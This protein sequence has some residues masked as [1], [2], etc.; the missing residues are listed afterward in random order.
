MVIFL[1]LLDVCAASPATNSH[2]W[3]YNNGDV[4]SD[5]RKMNIIAQFLINGC[6]KRAAA[7][8]CKCSEI[9]VYK[10]WN[11]FLTIGSVI[12]EKQK[13]GRKPRLSPEALH[14]LYWLSRAH[15]TYTIAECQDRLK[16]DLQLDVSAFIVVRALRALGQ[17]RKKPNSDQS[18]C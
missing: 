5:D 15:S 1:A 18:R 3:W 6:D 8:F 17:L 10:Y 11:R 16:C 4:L 9:I 2:G 14:Y 7:A 13:T 12:K